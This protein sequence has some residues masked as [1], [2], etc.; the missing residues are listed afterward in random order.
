MNR[1][2][3]YCKNNDRGSTLKPLSVLEAG[4][5]DACAFMPWADIKRRMMIGVSSEEVLTLTNKGH[6]A[7]RR[8]VAKRPAAKTHNAYLPAPSECA[9]Q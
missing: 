8:F 9:P 3:A 4:G 1:L 7:H 5:L 2:V 6:A